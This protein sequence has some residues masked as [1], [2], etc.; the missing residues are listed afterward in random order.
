MTCKPLVSGRRYAVAAGHPLAAMAGAE[1]LRSGGNAIDAGVAAGIATEVL[2][3]ILVGFGGVAPIIL[4]SAEHDEIVTISGLGTWP[5]AVDADYFNRLHGGRIPLGILRT[6]M[7]AAP[8]A[9]ITALAR[10][11]RMSFGEV[12]AFAIEFARDGFPMYEFFSARIAEKRAGFARYPS[13]AAIYLPNGAPP[14]VGEIFRQPELGAS[15]QF[16]ADQERAAA[17]RGGR[18]AGLAAARH[19]FYEGDIAHEM[20]A[21]VRAE[22][23]EMT[24]EDLRDFSVEVEKP[25]S[26]RFG[27]WQVNG[28]GPW[29][30]GPMLLQALNIVKTFDLK[31]LGHNSADYVHVLCEA[32]KLA[33]A[34]R[35]R[36]YGDPRFV[37]VPMERLLSDAHARAQ[38]ARIRFDRAT[39][40]ADEDDAAAAAKADL[41]VGDSTMDTSYVCAVDKEGNAFSATPSD[42]PHHAPVVPKLGFLVSARGSQ[43]W[44]D[45]RHPASVAPGKRPRLTPNPALAVGPDG[46]MMPFGSPGGDVQTQAMLQGFLNRVVFGFDTQQAVEAPRFATYDFPSSWEPHEREHLVLK[47]EQ[48]LDREVGAVLAGRGH[49]VQ[50]WPDM[51]WTAGSL[52]LIEHDR[53]QGRMSTGSDPRREGYAIGW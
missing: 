52:S 44:T 51:V 28:C 8:D 26:I 25:V 50:S 46:R 53:A 2:E 47:I 35:D 18:A 10:Y 34:D 22:G 19:A 32:I 33:A 1:I 15:I 40:F 12:A 42:A 6:V 27:D 45:P 43:S 37:D 7:P 39:S 36:Y 3:S 23:G 13:T 48:S 31:A 21:H 30:Q 16:L 5:K 38:A 11:G 14:V 24:M 17:A 9:W 20:V 49:K 41:I 4:Y 29:C